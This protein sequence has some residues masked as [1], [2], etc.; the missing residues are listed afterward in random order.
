M[1]LTKTGSFESS[2]LKEG[3]LYK[4]CTL[5][6]MKVTTAEKRAE[7]LLVE[8]NWDPNGATIHLD[9]GLGV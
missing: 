9:V 7:A 1:S 6:Q 4:T 8:N 2:S 3:N 5:L